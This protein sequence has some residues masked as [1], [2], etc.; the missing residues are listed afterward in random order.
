MP[1]RHPLASIH[2]RNPAL[3]ALA[4]EAGGTLL[5]SGRVRF[6]GLNSRQHQPILNTLRGTL[7]E[8]HVATREIDD[9]HDG[10]R[11]VRHEPAAADA[12]RAVREIRGWVATCQRWRCIAQSRMAARNEGNAAH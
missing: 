7:T 10:L 11:T 3:V 6:D 8:W 9:V 1:V 12:A 4:L 2:I 5:P